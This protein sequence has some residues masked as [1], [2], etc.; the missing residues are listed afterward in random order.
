[1]KLLIMQFS[2]IHLSSGLTFYPAPC[3]QTPSV[4]SRSTEDAS[5]NALQNSEFL[6]V[7]ACGR[8]RTCVLMCLERVIINKAE[9]P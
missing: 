1:M 5:L 3:S 7:L 4:A 8:V 9:L 6:R 2:P